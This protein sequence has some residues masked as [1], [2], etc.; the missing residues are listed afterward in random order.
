MQGINGFSS[1]CFLPLVKGEMPEGQRGLEE[2]TNTRFLQSI[3]EIACGQKAENPTVYAG[4]GSSQPDFFAN[5][6][7]AVG[8]NGQKNE[9]SI[10]DVLAEIEKLLSQLKQDK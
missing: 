4:Q 7:K 3:I 2:T 10:D 8:L 9:K 5:P 6:E 1:S